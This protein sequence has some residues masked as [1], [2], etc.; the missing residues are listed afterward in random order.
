MNTGTATRPERLRDKAA[1]SSHYDLPPEFFASFLGPRMA[2]SCAYFRSEDTPLAQAEEDKLTLTAEKLCLEPGDRVLDIGCGWGSFI[3]FAAERY[4]V[5]CVGITLAE[6]QARAVERRAAREG[7]RERVRA[8]VV[9]AYDMD[10]GAGA[11]D[12]I[13]TIGAIE[14]MEDLGRVFGRCSEM[15][16]DDGLMLVHGMTQPWRSRRRLMRGETD[17]ATRLLYEHFGV[18]HWHSLWEVVEGL[19]KNGFEI[20]DVENISQHYKLTVERWLDNLLANEDRIVGEGILP[21][22]KVR[23]F[24]AFFAAYV[25]SFEMSE[26]ICSQVLARKTLEGRLRDPYPLTRERMM[27]PPP[28]AEEG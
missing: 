5:T 16:A 24:I 9:H 3:H 17:E 4:G 19:E 14:H 2:Y 7:T 10:Y 25:V 21:D 1:I 26:T 23:E 11:F 6:E 15:L 18:G 22:E 28:S 27:M 8:D 13:V 12:K 20:L